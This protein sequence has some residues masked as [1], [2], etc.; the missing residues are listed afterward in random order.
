M[1]LL[2]ESGQHFTESIQEMKQLLQEIFV[3]EVRINVLLVPG[4]TRINFSNLNNSCESNSSSNIGSSTSSR[5]F[6]G[7]IFYSKF[8]F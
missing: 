3:S 7:S 8:G 6:I 1:A 2:F 5:D 4:Q